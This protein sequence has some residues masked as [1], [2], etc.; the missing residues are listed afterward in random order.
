MKKKGKQNSKTAEETL[1]EKEYRYRIISELVS[2]YAYSYCVEPGGELIYEWSTVESRPV[3]GY[4]EEDL[5]EI[6][7]W[8]SV[9]YT[10]DA[11]IVQKQLVSL[12]DNRSESIEYRIRAK[13]GHERWIR[14]YARPVWSEE[15]GRVIRI[16]GAIQDITDRKLIEKQTAEANKS[17][18]TI[19]D[20]IPADIYVSDMETHEIL[21]TNAQMIR[22]FGKDLTGEICWKVFRNETGPCPDCTNPDLLDDDKE[23]TGTIIWEG[24]NPITHQYYLNHDRAIRWVDDK[25]VRIEISIDISV[26]KQMESDLVDSEA[27]YRNLFE[28]KNEAVIFIDA[29]TM[30][31][32]DI[33]EA[34]CEM[35]G[36]T[37]EEMIGMKPGDISADA[38][39]TQQVLNRAVESDEKQNVKQR[40]HR[41]KNRETIVV[42]TSNNT[43]MAKNRKMICSTHRDIT[44]RK[45]SEELM[46]QTEKM[47]SVGGLAAGMAHELNNPLGGMLQ[48]AQNVQR[49]LTP[50]LLVNQKIAEELGI[51]LNKLQL[52]M[53]KRE[54][55]SFLQGI[56]E[57]GMK[58]AKIIT[59]MLQFSRRNE[60]RFA[61]VDLVNLM[62]KTLELA[63]QDYDLK[64]RYDFRNIDIQKDYESNLPFVPCTETEIEQVILNLLNNAAWAMSGEKKEIPPQIA[65]RIASDGE[66]ARI[67]IEDNGPGM[68]EEVRKRAFEPFYTTKPVGNGTGLGLAVSYM[69]ITNNHDGIIEVVSEPGKGARFIIRLPMKRDNVSRATGNHFSRSE[70]LPL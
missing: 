55:Y 54:I 5:R 41:K 42:E 57:S 11:E 7:G 39:S 26:R 69:I 47:M 20:S 38:E 2:E 37:R 32:V 34:A 24:M 66:L 31:F 23:V 17:L 6:G 44:E 45:R 70:E 3:V 60:S 46:I 30:Q 16:E 28:T 25:F 29:E 52:Y 13:N 14:D 33:N 27:K 10:E 19:L 36:Y 67:E 43:F 62:E 68:T 8:K 65:L 48:G 4:T 59:N 58:A 15:E 51:D 35:Y 61:P 63:S 22:S 9:I 40:T 50:E 49:R 1:Q 18:I 64:R 56:R 53:E 12:F 21:Y